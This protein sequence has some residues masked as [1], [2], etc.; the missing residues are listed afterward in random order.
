M[1]TPDLGQTT[2]PA[3]NALFTV[4]SG[5]RY[6]NFSQEQ[7]GQT[8]P[9]NFTISGSKTLIPG[10]ATRIAAT[11]VMFPWL[12]PN[13]IGG[14]SDT[15]R[16]YFNTGG[17]VTTFDVVIQ[18]GFYRPQDLAITIQN[19]VQTSFP[20]FTMTYGVFTASPTV[21]SE[22]PQFEYAT[23]VVGQQ[24]AFGRGLLYPTTLNFRTLFDIMGFKVDLSVVK[25]PPYT[26]QPSTGFSA[27][28]QS[29]L[30]LLQNIRY[31]DIV[32]PQ[33]TQ[34]QGMPDSTTF[35]IQRDSIIR[36]YLGASTNNTLTP[37]DP[38]FCPPGCAPF[39]IHRLYNY[40]K[41]MRWNAV[42]NI[43]SFIEFKVYDDL[44][45]LL[46]I[47]FGQVQ[48]NILGTFALLAG[49]DWNMSLLVTEN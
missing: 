2:R 18:G 16:L 22:S 11:E 37:A 30:T 49:N 42:Q 6:D 27:L 43:G 34:N 31:V 20:A 23:N 36:L 28:G 8:S 10:F 17:V 48:N 15:I 21:A 4:D 24:V 35:R 12:I 3:S 13:V 40:P 41:Q 47:D 38:N 9:Y 5:D 7:L 25:P 26:N 1:T 29:G 33:L 44:G 19:Q 32:S 14:Q 45:N 46:D 39:V